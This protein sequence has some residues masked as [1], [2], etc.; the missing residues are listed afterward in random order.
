MPSPLHEG[1]G[2]R[3]A[4]EILTAEKTRAGPRAQRRP[5]ERE[6]A[7][8]AAG[9]PS[10]WAP[11]Q[12][13]K[14]WPRACFERT[15]W[16]L[17]GQADCGR[18]HEREGDTPMTGRPRSPLSERRDHK[19][20][21]QADRPARGGGWT[22]GSVCRTLQGLHTEKEQQTQSQRR[23][24]ED[25][26]A[27][28]PPPQG[29]RAAQDRILPSQPG[30]GLGTM[31]LEHPPRGNMSDTRRRHRASLG[32]CPRHPG[33]VGA[34]GRQGPCEPQLRGGSRTSRAAAADGNK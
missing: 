10:V 1:E 30:P 23:P 17:E 24:R 18:G 3:N 26:S 29:R 6:R 31:T 15:E 22:G 20:R 16:G 9:S 4:A 11:P 8:G 13:T 21:G 19:G 5:L 12:R 2:T 14:R 27:A 33:L 34:P 7:P 25:R 32:G 28:A